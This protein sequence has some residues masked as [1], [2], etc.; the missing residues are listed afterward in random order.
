M[1]QAWPDVRSTRERAALLLGPAMGATGAVWVCWPFRNAGA[2]PIADLVAM[3]IAMPELEDPS[4][5]ASPATLAVFGAWSGGYTSVELVWLA[6]G[7]PPAHCRRGQFPDP[8]WRRPS[9]SVRCGI[10]STSVRRRFRGGLCSVMQASDDSCGRLSIAVYVVDG[11]EAV[12]SSG[13]D[14]RSGAARRP[15]G[16]HPAHPRMAPRPK[17]VGK[18][19]RRGHSTVRNV[20]APDDLSV[21]GCV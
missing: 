18:A 8:T 10:W 5:A 6:A 19:V 17:S 7:P 11:I 4:F 20:T 3:Y 15:D 21:S 16:A 13:S 14:A 2:D 1:W 12:H 9:W